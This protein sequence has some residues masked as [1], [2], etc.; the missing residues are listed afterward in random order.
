LIIEDIPI[1]NK[2]VQQNLGF[3]ALPCLV[4]EFK[5]FLIL[6]IAKVQ[7]YNRIKMNLMKV[8]YQFKQVKGR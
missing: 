3:A 6:G 1:D 7:N 2:G 4:I 8:I 5:L